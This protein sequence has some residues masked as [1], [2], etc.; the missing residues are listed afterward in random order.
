MDQDNVILGGVKTELEDFRRWLGTKLFELKEG[1][2]F[3]TFRSLIGLFLRQ[4]KHAYASY[5]RLNYS[6]IPYQKLIRNGFLLGIDT[7]L[8]RAKYEIQEA[9]EKTA[10]MKSQFSNDPIIQDYFLGNKDVNIDLKELEESLQKL[11][12][13]H[14]EFKVA[15]NYKDVESEANEKRRETQ[16]IRNEIYSLE[17]LIEQIRESLNQNAQISKTRIEDLYKAAGIKLPE[18]VVKEFHCCPTGLRVEG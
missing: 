17:S 4:G 18:M 16:T 2:P 13:D 5:D 12:T 11:E 3:L 8:I 9:L 6:E 10:K 14:T 15:E 1:I 7:E